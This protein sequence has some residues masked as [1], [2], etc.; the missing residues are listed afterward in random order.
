MHR[1]FSIGED[2]RLFEYDVYNSVGHDKLIVVGH[3]QI[4]Q[5]ALPTACIWYPKRDSKEGLI[6]TANN[7]YKM[8]VW[9]PSAQSSRTTC[10]GPTYGGEITKMKSLTIRGLDEKY[11]VYQTAVK[12]M[13]LI[14]MPIDG[15]PNKTMGLISHPDVITDFCVSN[16]GQYLFTC[17]GA[18]LSVKMWAIDV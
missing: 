15:N 8:K 3:F 4:E 14:K 17:G 12:V 10:L 7:E 2:R 16:N 1:L 11:L 5:E 13:G 6:L 18:D 9:N